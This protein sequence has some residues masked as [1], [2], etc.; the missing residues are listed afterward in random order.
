MLPF[1]SVRRLPEAFVPDIRAQ[2]AGGTSLRK[3]A[4]TYCVSHETI[5]QVLRTA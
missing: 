5:R 1:A 4:K 2:Y 3:L